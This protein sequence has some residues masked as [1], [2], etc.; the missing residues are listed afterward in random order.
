MTEN[1]T[2]EYEAG[3]AHDEFK[4]IRDTFRELWRRAKRHD[5]RWPVDKVYGDAVGFL[6]EDTWHNAYAG[7]KRRLI[8]YI[9]SNL[10]EMGGKLVFLPP[11]VVGVLQCV[12]DGI[13]IGDDTVDLV[14]DEAKEEAQ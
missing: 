8:H 9:Q 5:S 10:T 2:T 3:E 14:W 12:A 1:T 13:M 7:D 6:L 11:Q 4:Y